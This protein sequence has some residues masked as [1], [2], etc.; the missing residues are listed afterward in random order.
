MP[1]H[2]ALFSHGIDESNPPDS[3]NFLSES[4]PESFYDCS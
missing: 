2:S 3:F 4:I 1:K